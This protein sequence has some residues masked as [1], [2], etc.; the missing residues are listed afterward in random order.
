MTDRSDQPERPEQG[1]GGLPPELPREPRERA[2]GAAPGATAIDFDPASPIKSYL[3]IVYLLFV[4]P[5][6]FFRAMSVDGGYKQPWLFA[7]FSVLISWVGVIIFYRSTFLTALYPLA[8]LGILVFAGLV[9]FSATRLVG[10]KGAFQATFRVVAYTSFTIVFGPI[11]YLGLAAHI[12][13]LY[14]IAHGLAAVHG[15]NLI[16]G[17]LAVLIIEGALRLIQYQMLGQVITQQ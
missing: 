15:M 14:L 1:P 11:P 8:L 7:L 3:Y 13:G 10:G 5:Q 2:R 12:F 9:H 16:R 4:Y 17:G 6:T